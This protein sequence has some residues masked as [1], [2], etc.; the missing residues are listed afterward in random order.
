[1]GVNVDTE[2]VKRMDQIRQENKIESMEDLEKAVR[3]SG[4]D[5]EDFKANIRNEL[6]RQ[7]VMRRD[8]GSRIVAD[9][10]E[11]QKYYD[12]HKQQFIRPEQVYVREIFVNTEGKSEE[13]KIALKAKAEGLLQRVKGGEDFGELA[14][15]F[16]DGS[17]AAMG[18]ELGVFERGQLSPNL[19]QIAFQ[20]SRDQITDVI[21]TQT[22]YLI[23]QV[24]EHY[25]AGQ[26]P[27]EKVENE[28]LNQMYGEKMRPALRAYLDKLRDEN[29]VEVKPG[30][31]DTA[32]VS[33]RPIEEVPA[34]PEANATPGVGR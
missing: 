11:V 28:I 4:M 33:S 1:M 8:V 14:K 15:R 32:G 20:M 17:T 6:F 19:E 21:P 18:G 34:S 30:Y 7:E 10:A 12:E 31:V 13:E 24:L 23:L 25:V 16:S 2:V 27:L 9:P 5:Y 22:G 29:W 26:Q 3:A